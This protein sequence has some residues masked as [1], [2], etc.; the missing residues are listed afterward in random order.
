MNELDNQQNSKKKLDYKWVVVGACFLM[1]MITL[2]FCSSPKS[3]FIGPITEYLG[4]DRSTYSIN[5]SFR[6]ITTAIVSFFFGTLIKKF[7]ARKL[8]K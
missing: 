6:Y 1:V 3:Y 2:G 8:K 7:G 4:I 5:D